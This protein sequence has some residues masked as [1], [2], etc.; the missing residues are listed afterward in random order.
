MRVCSGRSCQTGGSDASRTKER[1]LYAN[2]V[3]RWEE[4]VSMLSHSHM[5][6]ESARVLESLRAKPSNLMKWAMSR[7]M[8]V[9]TAIGKE[10]QDSVVITLSMFPP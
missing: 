3:V 7:Q 6:S 4:N 9:D 10:V 2:D 8:I 5:K 1:S